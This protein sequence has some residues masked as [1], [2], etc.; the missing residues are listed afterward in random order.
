MC[1]SDLPENIGGG[2]RSAESGT[3][4]FNTPPPPGV[5]VERRVRNPSLLESIFGM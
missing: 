2:G 3:R 4:V 1:S 5:T